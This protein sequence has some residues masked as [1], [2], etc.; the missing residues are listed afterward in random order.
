MNQRVA[1]LRLQA[2][3]GKDL[4]AVCSIASNSSSDYSTFLKS[5]TGVLEGHQSTGGDSFV[6]WVISMPK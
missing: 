5:L 1:S 4:A 3:G 2:A 6:Y